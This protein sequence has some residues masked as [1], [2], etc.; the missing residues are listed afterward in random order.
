MSVCRNNVKWY[1]VAQTLKK[2]SIISATSPERCFSHCCCLMGNLLWTTA[3]SCSVIL[4]CT[5]IQFCTI[6]FQVCNYFT[7]IFMLL[8]KCSR[9]L[10]QE[11]TC[12]GGFVLWQRDKSRL[13]CTQSPLWLLLKKAKHG[14]QR[15]TSN[16]LYF[17][18]TLLNCT[19]AKSWVLTS[20]KRTFLV[21]IM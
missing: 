18:L 16:Q 14:I 9:E 10:Y 13:T 3:V 7:C 20:C 19:W 12:H 15:D 2:C 5:L 1:W 8:F 21:I 17:T 4:K 6:S 11:C